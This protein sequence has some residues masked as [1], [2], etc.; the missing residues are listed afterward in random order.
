MAVGGG[1]FFLSGV[2]AL[3]YQVSWQRILEL[4]SG[5]ESLSVA[6]IVG[7]FMAG[8]GIGSALGGAWSARVS[9][10]LSLGLFALVEWGVA[11]FG[12]FS[13]PCYYE[14]LS[15]RLWW[16]YSSPP[17]AAI[18]HFASL[19][20]PTSL[21]GM[22]LPL[23]A[24]GLVGE[25]AGAGRILGI[26]YGLNTLGGAF[27]ALLTPWVLM[28]FAG[29]RGAVV[30]GSLCNL[31]AGLLVLSQGGKLT[32][33]VLETPPPVPRPPGRSLVF[34]GALYA[35]SGFCALGLEIVWFRLIDVAVRS[36]AFTF[37]TVLAL[38]L[39]GCSVG[40]LV[41]ARF[42]RRIREPLRAFLIA[43]AGLLLCAGTAVVVLF[44]L[45]S[46]TP[47]VRS[48][49]SAWRAPMFFRFGRHFRPSA[50]A[51]MYGVLP[52][53]LF[54]LPTFLM[55]FSFPLLQRAV[56]DEPRA[57]GRK[58]GLLQAANVLGC[59]CGSLMTGLVLLSALGTAGTLRLLVGMGLVFA[60]LGVRE[61]GVRSAFGPLLLALG[62]VTAL[63]P[64]NRALWL[65]LHGS[66]DRSI[67]SEDATG[68]AA[69]T[70]A[71]GGAWRVWVGGKS[72]SSLPFGGFH[73][74]LGAL[75]VILH[76]EPRAVA[77]IGLGSGDTAWAAGC[78]GRATERVQVFEIC[79]PNL[80]VLEEFAAREARGPEAR[81][82]S[83]LLADP[84][85]HHV[86]ADGRNALQQDR[87]TY[88][89]IEIDALW[90]FIANAGDLSSVEFFK[91]G[92]SRLRQGGLFCTWSPTPR[93]RASFREAFPYV[94]AF[95]DGQIVVGSND[96]LPFDRGAWKGR[97]LDRD[98]GL[99]LGGARQE[100]V[101][102]GLR[103][104]RH[105]PS[106][107]P[108]DLDTDL[109]PKDEFRTPELS[110]AHRGPS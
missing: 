41:A 36:T 68:V 87:T 25:A 24:R 98:V 35:L 5:S 84:R 1:A 47:L 59:V 11:A 3:V 46:G 61:Q 26:L 79:G 55:G 20:I 10:R 69:L 93:I 43:Q 4:G 44:R 17:A 95:R 12:L 30:G 19:L 27:G 60:L 42:A 13:V 96:P 73:T 29:V 99:Y 100:E 91:L 33:A 75:P 14:V 94:A 86:V 52:G 34:W 50:I 105:L 48:F 21:M 90:P 82:L 78:R 72:I 2:A 6:L 103:S 58:V 108:S 23:L 107:G 40:S 9:R 51:K 88:D 97:V 56:Q 16:I 76:P 37:G 32:P 66:L 39:M 67:V 38:Y 8:I 92:A 106:E 31:A 80:R 81:D 49:V 63:M 83:M 18:A 104:A 102:E 109:F 53:L 74:L 71:R 77:I 85:I 45:P 101:L 110:L 62:F 65:R 54:G 70:P 64:G 57:V 22:S 7:A 15:R 28:R 89:V